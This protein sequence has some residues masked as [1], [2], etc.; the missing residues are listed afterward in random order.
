MYDLEKFEKELIEEGIAAGTINT[1]LCHIKEYFDWLLGSG[2]VEFKHLYRQNIL[3]YISYLKNVRKTDYKTGENHSLSGKT[4]NLKL[5][6]IAKYN[7]VMQPEDIVIK[8][9]DYIKIHENLVN[10]T[11]ITKEEID[12]F[13]QKLL[14]SEGCSNIRNYTI[15]TLMAYSGL[16]I[17]EVLDLKVQD[18]SYQ[19]YVIMVRNGK[20]GKQR[21]VIVNSKVINAIRE[22]MKIRKT[23]VESEYLFC[24]KRG[25]KLNRSTIN[26]AFASVSDRITP[27]K[28]RHFYCSNAME[29]GMFTIQEIAAQ[30][31]HSSLNTTMKYVHPNLKNMIE[32]AELL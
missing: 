30:A 2:E 14:Q 27:H 4:I 13:R 9:T 22:Y 5:V 12:I 6:A 21:S 17:S 16:R 23:E 11:D 26:S 7:R 10:P 28:L 8:K 32:K 1:Y 20:G 25:N 24:N 19:T 3:E 15:A 18:I 31:G 29:S